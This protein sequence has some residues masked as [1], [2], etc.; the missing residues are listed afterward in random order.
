MNWAGRPLGLMCT[1][2]GRLRKPGAPFQS[3]LVPHPKLHSQLL[4]VVPGNPLLLSNSYSLFTLITSNQ[5]K[6]EQ[7]QC[8]TSNSS[9]C[10]YFSPLD[11]P[12]EELMPLWSWRV[13]W[14]STWV[15][16]FKWTWIWPPSKTLVNHVVLGKQ[17]NLSEG[18]HHTCKISK[19][20]ILST[21]KLST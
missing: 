7:L 12:M 9:C 20:N 15:T 17:I 2:A 18:K 3:L 8:L 14:S 4:H 6:Y 19:Y 10:F 13:Y 21:E 11:I 1:G 16:E 5:S